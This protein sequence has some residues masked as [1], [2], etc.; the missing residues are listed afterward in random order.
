MKASMHE[1]TELLRRRPDFRRLWVG[2]IV[3]YLGDWLAYVAVSLFALE[4]GE[5]LLAVALVFVIHSRLRR[6]GSEAGRFQPTRV[7]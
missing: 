6:L 2:D 7:Q 5:S 3:S 4:H 1:V